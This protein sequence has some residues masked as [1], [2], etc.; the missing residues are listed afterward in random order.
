ML[1]VYSFY[2]LKKKA[3]LASVDLEFELKEAIALH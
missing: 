3:Q 2:R 1:L